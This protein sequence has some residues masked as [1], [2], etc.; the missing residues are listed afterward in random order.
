MDISTNTLCFCSKSAV[1][2]VCRKNS[3]ATFAKADAGVAFA[4]APAAK[5][6]FVAVFEEFALFAVGELEGFGAAFSSLEQAAGRV[7]RGAGDG[8]GGEQVAGAEVA[9]VAGV[10]GEHLGGSPVEVAGVATANAEWF[11]SII[12]HSCS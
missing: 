9:A 6:D 12:T 4:L 10:V 11:V 7:R 2:L 3:S 5:D 8:S 1:L